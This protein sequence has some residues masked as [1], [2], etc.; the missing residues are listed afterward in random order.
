MSVLISNHVSGLKWSLLVS[1][2]LVLSGTDGS[3][4]VFLMSAVLF[5]LFGTG[6][7]KSIPDYD[8]LCSL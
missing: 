8:G 3:L 7:D 5:V 2:G 6:M 1:S 4:Q